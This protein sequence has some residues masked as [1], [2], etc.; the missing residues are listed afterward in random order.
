MKWL[1]RLL[2]KQKGRFHKCFFFP[3]YTWLEKEDDGTWTLREGS[4]PSCRDLTTNIDN[5]P[6]CKKVLE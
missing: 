4:H 6:Y 1:V 2:S 3:K 5:C